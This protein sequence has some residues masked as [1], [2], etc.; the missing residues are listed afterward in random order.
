MATFAMLCGLMGSTAVVHADDEPLP[1]MELLEYLGSWD[2]SDEDWMALA[3][4]AIE[5]V[6]AEDEETA[7]ASAA[8]DTVETD[9]ES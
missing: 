5:Q 3:A 7:P 1:D 8:D 4:E 6:A 9:D 2:G